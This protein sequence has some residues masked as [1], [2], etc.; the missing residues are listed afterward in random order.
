MSTVTGAA[1]KLITAEEFMNMPDPPDGSKQE[2]LRGE[3][4][5]MPPPKPRHAACCSEVHFILKSHVKA[6]RLGILTCNDAGFV[7]E[8]DPDTVRGPDI[9][10]WSA[11]R[12]S[13]LPEGYFE[14][15]PDLAV[16]VISPSDTHHRIQE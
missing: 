4:I 6:N 15:P 3:I 9:A 12:A 13:E 2:L 14:I 8:H 16:E 5:T 10:F 11:A 7:T 1:K